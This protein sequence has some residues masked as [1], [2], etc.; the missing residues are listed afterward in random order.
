[1]SFDIAMIARILPTLAQGLRLTLEL[2]GLTIVLSTLSGLLVVLALMSRLRTLAVLTHCYIEIVRNTPVLVQMYFIFFGSG[3]AGFPLSGFT[4]GLIALTLQN[5]AYIAE[6][7]RAGI[8]SVSQ[9][10]IEAGLA[11]GLMRRATFWIVVLPQALRKVIPPIANQGVIIIKDT[12]LVATLSVAELTFQA[13]LL[14]D[15]TAAVYEV[16]FALALFYIVLTSSFTGLMR[17]VERRVRVV[18]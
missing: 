1:M 6:I 11:L 9:Q 15:R 2:S 4:A 8:Q 10:Q 3:V 16:F 7:Y 14:A 12:S 18:Q 5:A 17:L 13:R